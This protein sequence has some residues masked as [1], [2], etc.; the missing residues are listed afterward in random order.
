MSRERPIIFSAAM[1]RAIL[2]GRKTQTR[3][4]MKPQPRQLNEHKPDGYYAIKLPRFGVIR[5]R[6]FHGFPSFKDY[7][8]YGKSGD[9]LWVR[10]TWRASSCHDDL[11]PMKI[12]DGSSVEYAAD[13]EKIFTGKNRPSIFMPR[14]A[15]RITLEI[16]NVRV[17][18]LQDISEADAIAEGGQWTDNGPRKWLKPGIA[19][20][21]AYKINGWNEGW[22]HIGETDQ[23]KCLSSAK[24]SYA[25]LWESINGTGSW[26]ADPW[27]WVL[28]F[29]R[30]EQ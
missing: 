5:S 20:E 19:F 23:Y 30:V 2:E 9:R 22:S 6:K 12:P 1:V 8:P 26:D 16:T 25:N 10:E 29:K 11:S 18:R 21:D 3:R 13:Q 27:V 7:C 28:E 17:E 24:M 15:S 4:A 14:W